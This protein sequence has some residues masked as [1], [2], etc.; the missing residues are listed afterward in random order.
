M[1]A[2]ADTPSYQQMSDLLRE[3]RQVDRKLTEIRDNLALAG[4]LALGLLYS[5]AIIV[6]FVAIISRA[7]R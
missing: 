6:L 3:V 4:S 1:G 5:A 7:N 2:S